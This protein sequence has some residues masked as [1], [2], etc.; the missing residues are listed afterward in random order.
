M[1][2]TYSKSNS[3]LS[4]MNSRASALKSGFGDDPVGETYVA[5]YKDVSDSLAEIDDLLDRNKTDCDRARNIDVDRLK[6]DG[7]SLIATIK[8]FPDYG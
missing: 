8:S 1:D 2:V 3:A 7:E 6:R 4:D 5:F